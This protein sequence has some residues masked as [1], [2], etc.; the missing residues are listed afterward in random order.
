MKSGEISILYL[1]GYILASMKIKEFVDSNMEFFMEIFY[2][3]SA[4]R[5][6]NEIRN[7]NVLKGKDT[8]FKNFDVSLKNVEF[9]YGDKKIIDN[10]SF[11]AKQGM[12]T[13]IVGQS[14]CGK[15]T[16]LRLISRLYDYDKGE[17]LIDNQNIKEVSTES[18][19]KNIS[20]VFQD[21]KLFNTSIMENVRI[22]RKDA[23]DKEVIEACKLANCDF[24]EN[25][26]EG[27]ETNI[28]ENGEQLS[29]GERQRL[30]IARAFLKDAPILILDEISSSL[31]VDNEIKIQKSLNKLIKNKTVIIISHRMKSI[32]NVDKI[33]VLKEGKVEK[34]GTHKELL[35]SSDTYKNLLEKTKKAEEFVY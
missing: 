7:E 16:L 35:N 21:V 11:T 9:S 6:I 32:E 8:E 25:L 20:I 18:L 5:R 30:S 3:D 24:I 23:T 28:G 26:K 31:D 34:I 22:G 1:L 10:V 12:V 15:T 27:F 13:A 19:Y 17:I 33:V 2:I 29:G 4:V 14:G